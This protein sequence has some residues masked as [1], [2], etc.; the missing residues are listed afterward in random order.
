LRQKRTPS[1]RKDLETERLNLR[2]FTGSDADALAE[3]NADPEVMRYIG[4]G[5]PVTL[6]QTRLRLRGY[7]D[8]W[9]KH[10]FGLWAVVYKQD[11]AL[12]GC[13]GLQFVPDTAEIEIG[14]RFARSYWGRGLSTEAAI[15]SLRYGFDSLPFERIIGLAQPANVPSQRV[16]EKIGLNYEKDACYYNT[17]VRL[18]AISRQEYQAGRRAR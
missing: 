15:A 11:N 7:L 18:Y 10:D 9:R 4:N 17:T 12:I 1:E 3:I 13:C 2:L 14:F 6:E 5:K 16:M 8:H